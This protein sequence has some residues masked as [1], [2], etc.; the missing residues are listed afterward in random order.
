MCNCASLMRIF[1]LVWAWRRLAMRRRCLRRSG[2]QCLPVIVEPEGSTAVRPKGR[3]VRPAWRPAL[4]LRPAWRRATA[5]KDLRVFSGCVPYCRI[6]P[7]LTVP[8]FFCRQLSKAGLSG[9]AGRPAA[10]AQPDA[11]HGIVWPR[12]PKGAAGPKPTDRPVRHAAGRPKGAWAPVRR[13]R[14]PWT[15]SQDG[16]RARAAAPAGMPKGA[17]GQRR[18]SDTGGRQTGPQA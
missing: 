11:R 14:R 12:S 13:I 8:Y 4:E 5:G 18:Q 10:R 17:R 6:R 7:A 2:G 3:T 1:V 9:P 15:G 16:N